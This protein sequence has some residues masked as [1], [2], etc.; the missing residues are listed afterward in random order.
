M[1]ARIQPGSA[2]PADGGGT[3]RELT[4]AARRLPLWGVNN[5]SQCVRMRN[6]ASVLKK[7]RPT[8]RGGAR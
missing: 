4:F 8:L 6:L 5:L 1:L 3:M 2:G 7:M